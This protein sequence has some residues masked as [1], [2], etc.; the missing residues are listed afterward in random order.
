M[1]FFFAFAWSKAKEFR[2][3]LMIALRVR[4]NITAYQKANVILLLL[5]EHLSCGVANS[6]AIFKFQMYEM[7][8][9]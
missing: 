3:C 8:R 7:C 2:F 9:E 5:S 6:C 1:N 4:N